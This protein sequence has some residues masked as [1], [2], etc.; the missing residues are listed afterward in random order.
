V[1]GPDHYREAEKL[2]QQAHN[3][4]GLERYE[5]AA[6]YAAVAQAHAVLASVALGALDPDRGG[7]QVRPKGAMAEWGVSVR[8]AP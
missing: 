6:A 1:T 8:T 3:R 5:V 4:L 2:V 7:D